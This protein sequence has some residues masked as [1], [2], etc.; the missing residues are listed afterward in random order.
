[1]AKKR[2]KESSSKP[3]F[4]YTTI[5][6]SIAAIILAALVI[7]FVVKSGD[8]AKFHAGG[9]IPI[10][11]ISRITSQINWRSYGV[12]LKVKPTLLSEN[13]IMTDVTA[14][15]SSLDEATTTDGIPGIL[16]RS[17]N[18]SFNI[19]SGESITLSGLKDQTEGR[20]ESGWPFLSEI[21][22]IG[23]LFKTH[24]NN[25]NKKELLILITPH[26]HP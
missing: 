20:S 3:K 22:L 5:I 12:I 16:T 25:K 23:E 2:K 24:T 8:E 26:L 6:I 19:S 18:T 7:F 10:K 1:M 13:K 14:E 11:I 17:V 9:E 15:L 4:S 21:P